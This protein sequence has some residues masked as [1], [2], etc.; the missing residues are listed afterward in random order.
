LAGGASGHK[1]DSST[2]ILGVQGRHVIVNG[3][4][5]PVVTEDGRGV[6]VDLAHGGDLRAG[7]LEAKVEAAATGE[8]RQDAG[9]HR[10]PSNTTGANSAT[11]SA[12]G[13]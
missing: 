12:N 11:T 9:A 2:E 13:T 6:R 7:G 10:A 3:G 8:Q 1:V 4:I 5:G